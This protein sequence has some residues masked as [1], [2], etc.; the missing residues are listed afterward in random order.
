MAHPREAGR[1]HVLQEEAEKFLSTELGNSSLS[2]V[3]MYV[4]DGDMLRIA[5]DNRAFTNRRF[6]HIAS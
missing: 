1:Q 3:P 6:L 5:G 2:T 4:T